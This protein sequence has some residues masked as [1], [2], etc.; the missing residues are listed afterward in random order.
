MGRRSL[1]QGIVPTQGSNPGLPHCRRI[2]Y[3]LSHRRNPQILERVACPFSRGSSWRKNWTG[4]SCTAGR[5]FTYWATTEALGKVSKWHKIKKLR[6]NSLHSK[7][8]DRQCRRPG[9][10]PWR[11]EWQPT[12]V[13]LPGGFHRQR[14]LVGCSPWGHKESHNWRELACMHTNTWRRECARSLGHTAWH[15]TPVLLP[16][17]SHGWRSLV[18]CSPWGR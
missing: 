10:D 9:F 2:L 17:K 4:V 5:F 7:E 16:G 12:P 14:S 11:R 3:Q 13:F 18:G 1:L 8:S 6:S 15:P